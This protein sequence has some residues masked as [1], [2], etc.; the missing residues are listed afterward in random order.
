MADAR[1]NI[2]TLK[3]WNSGTD[4]RALN[5]LDIYQ[6]LLIVFIVRELVRVAS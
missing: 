3:E 6:S 5:P 1:F 4:M 2:A